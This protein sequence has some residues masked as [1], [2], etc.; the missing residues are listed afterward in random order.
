MRGLV[1][2]NDVIACAESWVGTPF[3]H[4]GAI[5]GVGADCV[6]FL[7]GVALETGL[8]TPEL[9][10]TW[11]TDYSMQP[12]AGELRRLTSRHL[13]LVPYDHR[14]PG[15]IVLMRF[16]L[17]PQHLGMLTARDPDYVI[18]CAE[19]GVVEHRLDSVWR[20]RIVRVYRFPA[21]TPTLTLP[22]PT[23][24]EPAEID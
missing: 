3:R 1:T 11:P 17:E 13:T 16:A 4:Q 15:D 8:V 12:S 19:K 22:R 2:P 23:G 18:H 6:G 9:A 21:L 24:E 10:A 20:T 7:K 14:A 5:K